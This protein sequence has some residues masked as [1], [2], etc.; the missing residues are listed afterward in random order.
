MPPEARAFPNSW[1]CTSRAQCT[2]PGVI[3]GPLP[4]CQAGS[5]IVQAEEA[6][7]LWESLREEMGV[8]GKKKH[9]EGP[10]TATLDWRDIRK[11][12][13]APYGGSSG[14]TPEMRDRCAGL[15]PVWATAAEG[16]VQRWGLVAYV[17]QQVEGGTMEGAFGLFTDPEHLRPICRLLEPE[18]GDEGRLTYTAADEHGATIGTI[19]KEPPSRRPFKHTWRI[20]TPGGQIIH[21]RNSIATKQAHLQAARETLNPFNFVS[22]ALDEGGGSEIGPRG[23]RLLWVDPADEHKPARRSYLMSSR[24]ADFAAITELGAATIDRRL[25]LLAAVA[26]AR[27]LNLSPFTA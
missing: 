6:G 11:F 4:T 22:T 21:G 10:L 12:S 2:A 27:S 20:G 25:A 19:T 3:R 13:A 7:L 24:S 18:K 23:R 14:I 9:D 5:P 16:F 17:D 8:F 26:E 15:T 1:L